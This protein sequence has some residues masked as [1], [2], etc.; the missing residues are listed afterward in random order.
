MIFYDCRIVFERFAG[1]MAAEIEKRAPNIKLPQ[2]MKAPRPSGSKNFWEAEVIQEFNSA[3]LE[4]EEYNKV[5]MLIYEARPT[6]FGLI[7]V[8]DSMERITPTS[9]LS[10][11]KFFLKEDFL[12]D[13]EYGVRNVRMKSLKEITP[14]Q[15]F[16]LF[17]IADGRNRYTS[18]MN[19]W[20]RNGLFGDEDFTFNFF[21]NMDFNFKDG[22]IDAK[23]LTKKSALR[24]AQQLMLDQTFIDEL[25][26][27]Y[28]KDHPKK[29]VGIPI[30]YALKVKNSQGVMPIVNLLCRALYTNHRLVGRC[31]SKISEITERAFEDT[32]IDSVFKQSAGNTLIIELRGSQEDHANYASCYHRVVNYF[33][34]LVKKYQQSTQLILVEESDNPGFSPKFIASVQ[35]EVQLVEIKE[36]AG[37]RDVAF[38]YLKNLAKEGGLT[39]YSDEDLE[40]ALGENKTFRPS[41][42]SEIYENLRRD[43]L[44]NNIYTSY[45]DVARVRI[46]GDNLMGNDAYKA[47]HEMI[48]LTEVKKLLGEIIDNFKVQKARSR[49]GLNQ[50]RMSRH[51]VFTGNPGTAKTSVARLLA[52][53]F[54]K[55]GILDSGNYVECGR[56]DLIGEYVGQTAPR[57]RNKFRE[58]RGGVLMIDEAY[59]LVDD[60]RNGY[61]DEAISTIVQEMENNRETTIVIFCGYPKKMSDF[62]KVNEGLRSRIAFHIE[63]PDYKA[64]ELVE[65]LKLF[66]KNDGYKISP[67]IEEKCR[68]IFAEACRKK[69]FGNGRFVRNL[70]EQARL[71]Q[72]SRI[73]R[74]NGGT[75]FPR[76]ILTQ[77]KPEDFDVNAAE[78]YGVDER[79]IGFARKI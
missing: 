36:G 55:E 29:F 41:D 52:Q 40:R 53:I 77:L 17:S 5:A 2:W 49:A 22:L 70:W 23:A 24:Q 8:T 30:H 1:D 43:N 6:E 50:Q 28:S 33:S 60:Y 56:A 31:I 37:N 13:E 20:S 57:V 71:K 42:L 14:I 72:S 10:L 16:K 15:A 35:D 39:A 38:E 65:I 48:G 46:S 27:I 59:S 9:V 75:E 26:R 44:R 62:L 74:E 47:L 18:Y 7:I 32:D 61:G 68:G 21:R 78:K 3:L 12:D 45:R 63:F 69:D 54:T 76:E 34:S 73:C 51:M 66:V 19:D 67:E 79:A 64:D 25:E 58:A 4:S 11:F